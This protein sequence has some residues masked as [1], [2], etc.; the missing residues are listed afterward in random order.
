LVDLAQYLSGWIIFGLWELDFDDGIGNWEIW[1]NW[2]N[3]GLER[4]L[5]FPISTVVIY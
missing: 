2:E 1:V 5:D 4:F 3:F